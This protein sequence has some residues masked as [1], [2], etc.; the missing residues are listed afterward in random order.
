MTDLTDRAAVVDAIIAERPSTITVHR[1]SS[2]S[3]TG[4]TTL[5]PF[6]GRID[7]RGVDVGR[8]TSPGH[9]GPVAIMTYILLCPEASRVVQAKDLIKAVD[10][11]GG[12]SWYNVLN[13]RDYGYKQECILVGRDET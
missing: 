12:T 4:E 1:R 10:E 3:Q 9:A 13:A 8:D 7:E 11:A 2:T 5:A 6:V